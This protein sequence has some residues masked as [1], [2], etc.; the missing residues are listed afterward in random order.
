MLTKAIAIITVIDDMY[1]V[2]GTLAELEL[3]TDAVERLVE[4]CFIYFKW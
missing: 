4:K 3:F 2:Y 1:D